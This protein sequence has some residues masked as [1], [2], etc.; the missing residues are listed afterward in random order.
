MREI[1]YLHRSFSAKETYD[2]WHFSEKRPATQTSPDLRTGDIRHL[3]T[4][5]LAR[6]EISMSDLHIELQ[7]NV[8]YQIERPISKN[9]RKKGIQTGLHYT[10]S[11]GWAVQLL[12]RAAS[13]GESK[14]GSGAKAPQLATRAG[15]PCI[16]ATLQS[17]LYLLSLR[18]NINIDARTSL[19]SRTSFDS[20]NL[21]TTFY[22][23]KLP[24]IWLLIHENQTEMAHVCVS[25]T[26][27]SGELN[28][29]TDA[30][31]SIDPWTFL[32]LPLSHALP[33]TLSI[34]L[35]HS[36]FFIDCFFFLTRSYLSVS[37]FL[38]FSLPPLL[39]S[40]APPLCIYAPYVTV[41]THTNANIQIHI[42][43][44]IWHTRRIESLTSARRVANGAV[45]YKS[46]S[47]SAYN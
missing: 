36:S 15:I 2:W 20:R 6:S 21:T 22:D 5:D 47:D 24:Q 25:S 30:D 12:W 29:E 42:Y 37:I 1:P 27:R 31:I 46:S 23:G 39:P 40:P 44:N 8:R 26:E 41:H 17:Y 10:Q 43:T 9:I 4:S 28:G 45:R 34:F 19:D 32:S 13:S 38:C 35:S 3:P 16:F 33:L 7:F 18:K 11:V 14:D